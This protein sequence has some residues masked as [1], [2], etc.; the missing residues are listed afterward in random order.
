MINLRTPLAGLFEEEEDDDD[1]S[2]NN[3]ML[4]RN[5]Y[6]INKQMQDCEMKVLV[7]IINKTITSQR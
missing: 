3:I 5:K 7:I 1:I 2:D 4:I 6:I